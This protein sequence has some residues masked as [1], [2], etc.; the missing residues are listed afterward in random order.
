MDE[1]VIQPTQPTTPS[2]EDQQK[3]IDE[4]ASQIAAEKVD[5]L[6]DDLAQRISG[7]AP[8]AAPKSW[9]EFRDGVEST[10]TER[11]VKAAEA[12]IEKRFADEKKRQEDTAK[13]TVKQ[14]EDAQTAEWTQMTREWTEAVKDGIIPDIAEPI[15]Q[16]L[17]TG[18]ALADLTEAEQKDPG[19]KAYNDA[20]LLHIDLK[21][22][23]ESSSFYRTLDKFYN[24]Q[25]PGTQAPVIGGGVPT[26]APGD[27]YDYDAVV[28]NR[29]KRFGY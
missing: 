20:R 2:L 1:P 27:D 28:A 3:L 15:K 29:R 17:K 6:K 12:A 8:E 24:K 25:H 9:Q 16:K 22:K 26:A 14:Q 13:L 18:T 10:S 4:R 5:K 23:G 11:A 21:Q 7:R 19:L